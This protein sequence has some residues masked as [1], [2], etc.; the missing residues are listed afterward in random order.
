[1]DLYELL[2]KNLSLIE[3]GKT[4]EAGI[5]HPKAWFNKNVG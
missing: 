3:I 5:S 1:M 4:S 2:N